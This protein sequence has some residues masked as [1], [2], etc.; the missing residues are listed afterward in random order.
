[1]TINTFKGDCLDL[2]L[3]LEDESI[4]AIYLDPPFFS[5]KVQ[6][7]M[8]RD[9]LS[10]FSFNDAWRCHTE[11]VKF[12]HER[13]AS[14]KRVLKQ[15]GS[16]FVH[17]DKNSSHFVRAILDD[18]FEKEQFR[19]EIIWY[20]KRW[21]NSKKGLLHSHQTI[22]FYSKTNKFTF[23][24]IYTNY[25]ET[26]NIDQILQKRARDKHGKAV[27]AK[28]ENGTVVLDGA[29]KGVPLGDVWEIPYLNPKAKER[30]GYPTQKPVI[31][32]ERIISICTDPD[33]TILDPFCGSGTTLVAAKILGRNAIGFD[34]SDDAIK[35]TDE[36]LKHIYKSE[37]QLLKNGRESYINVNQNALALLDGV[38]YVP[39]QRN[40]GVDAILKQ[41]HQNTPILVRVQKT[42]ESLSDSI[43]ALSLAAKKKGAKLSIL[44]KTNND[45]P[46]FEGFIP[47]NIIIID[48]VGASIFKLL[49]SQ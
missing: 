14:F 31:L 40:N 34:I 25:S 7:L 35:I 26:T 27:Y 45:Q 4:D 36:R 29:K 3:N 10:E 49:A 32:L 9:R 38:D 43:R 8:T 22:F 39:V 2:I 18:V 37:S 17:C 11:Y 46:L 12:L 42:G 15:S 48:S 19:S 44:V 30:V 33:N 28:D 6:K 13:I 20:Y 16:I 24:T 1:M 41:Q 47:E 5:G 23:N 21:S